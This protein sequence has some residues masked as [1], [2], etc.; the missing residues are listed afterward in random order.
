MKL[1]LHTSALSKPLHVASPDW[2]NLYS[3]SLDEL[4]IPDAIFSYTKQRNRSSFDDARLCDTRPTRYLALPSF[5]VAKHVNS[6]T[7]HNNNGNEKRGLLVS[8]SPSPL[9]SNQTYLYSLSPGH[10]DMPE[11]SIINGY[12]LCNSLYSILGYNIHHDHDYM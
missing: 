9:N 8:S 7:G 4:P 11:N 6:S 1:H 12:P 3:N 5:H 2:A 10:Q